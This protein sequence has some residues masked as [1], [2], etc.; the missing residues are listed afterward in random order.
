MKI[1]L[2]FLDQEEWYERS[3]VKNSEIFNVTGKSWEEQYRIISTD[4][5]VAIL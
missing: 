4:R 5:F 2:I 1:I 3:E